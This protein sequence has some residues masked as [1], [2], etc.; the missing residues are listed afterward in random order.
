MAD[1][2]QAVRRDFAARVGDSA[3]VR[4]LMASD[5]ILAAR[6]SSILDADGLPGRSKVGPAGAD[7]SM[8]I[9]QHSWS[10]QLRALALAKALPVGEISPPSL[11]MLEDRVLVHQGHRQRFGTQFDIGLDGRFRFAPVSDVA[12]LATRRERAGLP[13]F[14]QYLCLLE[15][16]GLKI[17]RASVPEVLRRNRA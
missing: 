1:R 10:L 13:P 12:G 11:A 4:E 5:S 17:D 7:A 2:D 14:D 8:L 16:S 6:L 15:E 3:Y 9:I